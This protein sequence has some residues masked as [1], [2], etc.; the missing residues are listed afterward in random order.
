MFS[1][2]DRLGLRTWIEISREAIAHNFNAF[3]NHVPKEVKLMSV[4]KS[5]A[6]GHGLV[7]FSQEMT[8]LGIDWLGVDSIVEA[9]RLRKEGIEKPILV[10]GYTLPELMQEAVDQ[11]I[12]VTVSSMYAAQGLK[13][14]NLQ[15]K[16]KV[17][18]KIDSGMHRQGFMEPE[19]D[20]LISLLKANTENVLVEGLYTHFASAKNP[21]ETEITTNQ[22]RLFNKWVER[23][24]AEGFS[25]IIHAAATGATLLFKE[26]YFDMVRVG[27]GLHG[28][29]PSDEVG[30][31]MKDKISL[32]RTLSWKTIVSELKTIPKGDGVG[33]DLTEVMTRETR[34]AVCPIGYWHGFPRSLSS[35]GTVLVNGA[36]ARV[37]GRV[38]MDM[39]VIDVTDVPDPK[40]GDEVILIGQSETACIEAD[41]IAKTAG[42]SPYEFIT[43]IN[44]LIKK[45][46][47]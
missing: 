24:K 40:V 1:K 18:I 9:I 25:P 27:I 11:D 37:L 31:Y 36:Q 23:F 8:K 16:L 5:N 47:Y 10:L 19:V 13:K 29:W 38:S 43:R 2:E 44:P 33:Y 45:F 39:I 22:V 17:H 4:V 28:L 12:S 21:T 42:Y 35:K 32:K 6:Y 20:E 14:L 26:T 15:G 46:Y 30:E 3:R 41:E 34:L 7:H